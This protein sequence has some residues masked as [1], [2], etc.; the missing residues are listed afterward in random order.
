MVNDTDKNRYRPE[1]SFF[2]FE[3]SDQFT[4]TY[5]VKTAMAV[6]MTA[7]VAHETTHTDARSCDATQSSHEVISRFG[8]K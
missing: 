7:S 2:M 3:L 4:L 5:F 8:R 6:T 1:K